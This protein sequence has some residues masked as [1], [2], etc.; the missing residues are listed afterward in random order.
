M[1]VLVFAGTTEGREITE[2]LAENGV[3]VTAC[4]ATEYG[5]MLMPF[6]ESIEVRAGR[7]TQE[8]MEALLKDY[9]F[10]IDATHPYAQIVTKNI[11]T[12]CAIL[13]IEYIRLCRPSISTG[14][15]VAVSD[16]RAAAEFLNTV[17]GNVLLTTGSKELEAF[18]AVRDFDKRLFARVLPT[19]EVVERCEELGF[20]GK[21]LICMQGPFSHDM[22]IATLKQI[23]AR[24]IVTK[25]TG[26]AGGYDEKVSAAVAAGATV[27]H[28]AR[29]AEPDGLTAEQLKT[30]LARKCG[31]NPR[32]MEKSHNKRFPMFVDI[33]GK[34]VLVAGGG[35]IAAR[36]VKV[37]LGFGA[38]VL[39]VSPLLTEELQNLRKAGLISYIKDSYS[40]KY[41]ENIFIA[42]AATND[43]IAN[44]QVFLDARERKIPVSVADC[45]EECS[46]YF[47]AVFEF[48]GIV[49]GL[50]SV[51]G[52][53][54][55]MV[56]E[57]ARKI[58]SIG[59]E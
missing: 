3:E 24:Y 17:E 7:L 36:R 27:V 59:A 6:H 37:L 48:D 9:A 16:T 32:F 54:H 15:V 51:T 45:R 39:L 26:A 8:Q 50:V 41:I 2:F 47:P 58:R 29:P 53:E 35:Q 21:N 52:K 46:F 43:R 4:V 44:H 23:N 13:N 42:I 40:S 56:K 1:R 31:F 12:A 5:S 49:G 25:D 33:T 10:V 18:T 19:A 22:N 57:A 55:A 38:E 11:K 14:N 34:G 20:K 30:E 28:I